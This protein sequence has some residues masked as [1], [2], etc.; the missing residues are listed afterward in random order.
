MGFHRVG[1]GRQFEVECEG[2]SQAVLISDIAMSESK[3]AKLYRKDH[4]QI[5]QMRYQIESGC[6]MMPVIL[7]VCIGGGYTIE[8][9]RHRFVAAKLAGTTHIDAIIVD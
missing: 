6:D 4:A 7:H 1:Y 3:I 8:D 2:V 9:G 5:E